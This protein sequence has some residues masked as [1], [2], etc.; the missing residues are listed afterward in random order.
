[1]KNDAQLIWEAHTQPIPQEVIS[2]LVYIPLPQGLDDQEYSD[3]EMR[4]GLGGA[5]QI[6]VGTGIVTSLEFEA[7]VRGTIESAR[8]YFN[9]EEERY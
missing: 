1:M 3:Y 2:Q 7:D 6:F 9:D 8:K 5:E 4:F